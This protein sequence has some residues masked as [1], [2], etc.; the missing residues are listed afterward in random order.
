MNFPWHV[1]AILLGGVLLAAAVRSKE[2]FAL[3]YKL[4]CALRMLVIMPAVIIGTIAI[5]D[6]YHIIQ[7]DVAELIYFFAGGFIYIVIAL[8][9]DNIVERIAEKHGIRL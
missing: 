7:S 3:L 5:G 2:A 9:I 1:I 4:F 8:V 6:Y